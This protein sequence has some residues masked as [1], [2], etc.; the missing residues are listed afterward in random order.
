MWICYTRLAAQALALGEIK[1]AENVLKHAFF[2]VTRT[3]TQ[4]PVVRYARSQRENKGVEWLFH[5]VVFASLHLA[6]HDPG[7]AKTH[8][9]E[10]LH[11]NNEIKC[12]TFARAAKLYEMET[13]PKNDKRRRIDAYVGAFNVPAQTHWTYFPNLPQS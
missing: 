1:F 11:R 12:L 9:I 7:G 6:K 8:L 13:Y 4:N 2:Y 5:Q 3:D 10:P